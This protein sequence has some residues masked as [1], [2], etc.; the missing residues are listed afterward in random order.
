MSSSRVFASITGI[1]TGLSG[2]AHGFFEM[3]QGNRP[4]PGLFMDGMGALS[5][6]PNY[7]YTG[8]AAALIGFAV[9][10]WSVVRLHRRGG[11]SVFAVLAV[12]L[13]ATGGG[14]ALIAGIA[15]TAAVSSRI[16]KPLSWW[17]RILPGGAKRV[18]ASVWL[19]A[20]IL[21]YGF[22]GAGIA[23]W[24]VVNPPGPMRPIGPWHYAC[25][26]FLAFGV[27]LL[28]SAIV[29]GFARDIARAPA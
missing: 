10:T 21:G 5:I 8:L 26:S 23:I 28:L 19:P 22:L 13:V 24:L 29:A 15:L 16:G 27:L 25:W 4:T 1:I 6:L 17:R 18:L 7:F 12:L 3:G 14:I 20:L 11:P 9:A 2:A